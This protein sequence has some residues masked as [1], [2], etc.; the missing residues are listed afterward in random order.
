M[1]DKLAEREKRRAEI[2]RITRDLMN[3]PTKSQVDSVDAADGV[4]DNVVAEDVEAGM[5]EEE[6]EDDQEKTTP[7]V[8]SK[9]TAQ[10][11]QLPV[12]C[13]ASLKGHTKAVTALSVDAGGGRVA[14]GGTDYMVRLYDFGGMDKHHRSFREF[15][16]EE[17]NMVVALSH[18]PSG[19]KFL[20]CTAGS[21]PKIYSRDGV[22]L[23]Q[24]TRGDP[25][26]RDMRQTK[27]HI[28]VV[29]GGQ[30]HPTEKNTV[31]TSSMDGT[32]RVW[33]LNGP[34]AFDKLCCKLVLRLKAPRAG[35]KA[36]CTAISYCAEGKTVA[37]GGG[38][39]SV[40]LLP[41]AGGTG[42]STAMGKIVEAAHGRNMVVTSVAWHDD[43][44][45]LASRGTD[46]SVRLWDIRKFTEAVKII[47]GVETH[48]E[49]SNTAFSPDG[50]IIACGINTDPRSQDSGLIKFYPVHGP[51]VEP[52]LS[53]GVAGPG[54]SVVRVLWHPKIKQIFASTTG[55]YTKVLYDPSMSEK[56][57]LM[58]SG[59]SYRSRT[60]D[61]TPEGQV[62]EII[63]PHALPM[64]RT[65][66]TTKRK[67]AE[68]ARK[69]PKRSKKPEPPHN[70]PGVGGK[71]ASSYN[72][73]QFV[74][75]QKLEGD[76]SR[77]GTLRGLRD[78]DA[79]E[80]LL[81]HDSGAKDAPDYFGRAYGQNKVKLAEKT[82][83]EE[84]AEFKEEQ[85]RLLDT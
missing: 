39:G 38:D 61:F 84:E 14:T 12:S 82:L 34:Q 7:E 56:G 37:V 69:D 60:M 15:E 80:E 46:G 33:D 2:E 63:N 30:W 68:Q 55:G 21:Q 58:T 66:T 48:M 50:R 23:L 24:F 29:T 78:Q 18:S 28:T 72:F 25:Y 76:K 43:G 47:R 45:L 19:D 1:S 83:E 17:G 51:D 36:T 70:G 42:G 79:R 3:P 81:K 52:E 57:A 10:R 74:L 53:I 71:V 11:L 44:H 13:E 8:L 5:E 49:T 26:L 22:E 32:A 6:E 85:R 64:Y 4:T 67:E 59:R 9:R 41:A 73:T 62:G 40:R 35:G 27:G 54:V 77:G 65:T 20:A 75:K 16:V 31:L